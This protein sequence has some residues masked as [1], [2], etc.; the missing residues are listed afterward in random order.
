MS[1]DQIRSV[2]LKNCEQWVLHS[3]IVGLDYEISVGHPPN[4]MPTQSCYPVVYL[5][6]ADASFGLVYDMIKMLNVSG[7]L[8]AILLVGIGYPEDDLESFA[9]RRLQDFTPSV[10]KD[11]KKIWESELALFENGGGAEKFLDFL[12]HELF[13]KIGEKYA[14]KENDRTLIGHSLAGLFALYTLLHVPLIFKRYVVGSPAIFWDDGFL[15]RHENKYTA[16]NEALDARVFIGVGGDE[17]KNPLH[18]PVDK[19]EMMAGISLVNDVRKMTDL[20]AR[21]KLIGL[22]IESKIF[23]NE[24]HMSVIATCINKGLRSVFN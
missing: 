2:R 1:N 14:A 3:D 12:Q 11:Y 24:T 8:P 15:W 7:E 10:D 21:R 9:N 19:R 5:L 6:D 13:P 20:L 17:D 23:E 16:E 22:E 18:F 4:W